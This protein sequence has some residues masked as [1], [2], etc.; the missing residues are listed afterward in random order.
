MPTYIYGCDNNNY[1]DLHIEVIQ[2]IKSD[3]FTSMGQLAD[4]IDGG[5]HIDV[6]QKTS[7]DNWEEVEGFYINDELRD[8]VCYRVFCSPVLIFKG[9]GWTSKSGNMQ[10]TGKHKKKV[11]E[12]REKRHNRVKKGISLSDVGASSS[13]VSEKEWDRMSSKQKKTAREIGVTPAKETV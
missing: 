10:Y 5:G 6:Y 1:S 3:P 11:E 9:T 2:S 12:L 13:A 4:Y 7:D 8:V